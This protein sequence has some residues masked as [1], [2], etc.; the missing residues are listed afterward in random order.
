MMLV[1]GTTAVPAAAWAVAAWS[2]LAGEMLIRAGGGLVDPG[3]AASARLA[4]AAVSLCPAM[5]LLGA[6]RPQH[7]VWQ[8]IVATLAFV[9]ALPSLSALLVR[10]GSQPDVQIGRAHV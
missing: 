10:P 9:L 6:K 5:S 4:V 1:R 2:S 7:G 8:F 3:T